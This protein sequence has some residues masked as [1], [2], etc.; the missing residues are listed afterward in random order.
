MPKYEFAI[1]NEKVRAAVKEGDSFPGYEDSW[2]DMHYIEAAGTVVD[3]ARA[4]IDR[5]YPARHGFVVDHFT[6]VEPDG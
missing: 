4:T 2:A 6:E 3:M 1:F 5:Q